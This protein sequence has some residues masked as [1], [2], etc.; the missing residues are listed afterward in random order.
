[1]SQVMSLREKVA[2]AELALRSYG[3][4]KRNDERNSSDG[5]SGQSNLRMEKPFSPRSENANEQH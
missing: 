4:Y 3:S 5:A 1:M 2:Q